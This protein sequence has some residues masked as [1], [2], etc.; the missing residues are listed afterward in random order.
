MARGDLADPG[1]DL[2]QE[3]F[4]GRHTGDDDGE[5][6]FDDAGG[7]WVGMLSEKER[8]VETYVQIAKDTV[9]VVAS[10]A[11]AGSL[12][13]WTRQARRTQLAMVTL[14]SGMSIKNLVTSR[15]L[16]RCQPQICS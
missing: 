4:N 12:S 8:K 14:R 3:G 6:H 13:D 5:V 2:V 11:L 7:V 9:E 10:R 1:A 15:S 16:T